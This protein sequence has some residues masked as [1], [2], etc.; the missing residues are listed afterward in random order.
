MHEYLAT[1]AEA[2]KQDAGNN[3]PERELFVGDV[4]QAAIHDGLRVEAVLFPNGTYLDVGTPDDLVRA[5]RN[6]VQVT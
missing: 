1:A 6:F 5:V 2:N 3:R 4:I